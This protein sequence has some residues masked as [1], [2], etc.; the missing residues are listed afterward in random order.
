MFSKTLLPVYLLLVLVAMPNAYA[1][2]STC[3]D[4]Q[5]VRQWVPVNDETLLI[6]AGRQKY[7]ISFQNSC[8]HLNSSASLLFK[9]DPIS[10]RV[11]SST[12]NYISARGE[13]CRIQ[14]I[15]EIDRATFKAESSKKRASISIKKS[16]A[17]ENSNEP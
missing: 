3:F 16:K 14:R 15:T 5:R 4:S 7:R 6:D 17:V 9:G 2:A 10:G 13:I 1:A 11:C 12:L 8:S